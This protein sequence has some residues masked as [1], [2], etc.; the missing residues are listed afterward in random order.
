[1]KQEAASLPDRR[2]LLVGFGTQQRATMRDLLQGFGIRLTGSVAN[3]QHLLS[4]AE[5]GASFDCVIVNFDAFADPVDGVEAL[6]E[7]RARSDGFSVVVCS[8]EVKGDDLSS[9]R[10]AICDATLRLPATG[11]RLREAL[12]A[13]CG[14]T[15]LRRLARMARPA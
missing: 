9:E 5:L 4:I 2:V 10:K 1:M 7:F 14:N 3:V 13:A 12:V 8:T 15:A 6:L 11:D